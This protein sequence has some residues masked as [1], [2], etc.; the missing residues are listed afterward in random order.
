MHQRIVAALLLLVSH[1]CWADSACAPLK[2]GWAYDE[3][4]V[5]R[6]CVLQVRMCKPLSRPV[7]LVLPP[8]APMSVNH[9]LSLTELQALVVSGKSAVQTSAKKRGR[10]FTNPFLHVLDQDPQAVA[11]EG[12]PSKHSFCVYVNSLVLSPT[13]VEVYIPKEFAEGSCYYKVVKA[14]ETKHYDDSVRLLGEFYADLKTYLDL[15]TS[16]DPKPMWAE[17]GDQAVA[18]LS[19]SLTEYIHEHRAALH[20]RL[21]EAKND[22]DTEEQSIADD[23]LCKNWPD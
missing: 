13:T 5:V 10:T 3:D 4:K 17:S 1:A 12:D 19:A 7:N 2:N 11:A 16:K 21:T 18:Q 15:Y 22:F 20:D 9:K 8:I 23:K 14:H 6:G